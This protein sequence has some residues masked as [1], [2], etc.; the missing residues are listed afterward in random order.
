M[1]YGSADDRCQ[2]TSRT[3]EVLWRPQSRVLRR[4]LLLPP[5]LA[6]VGMVMLFP[7]RGDADNVRFMLSIYGQALLPPL[8]GWIAAGLLMGDPCRELLLAAPRPAWRALCERAALLGASA[9]AALVAL[10]AFTLLVPDGVVAPYAGQLFVGGAAVS[11]AFGGLGL[12]AGVRTRSPLAGGLIVAALWAAGLAFREQL[13]SYPLGQALHPCLLLAEP[14]SPPWL[15][16]GLA[17]GLA[18]AALAGLAL[19]ATRDEEPLLPGGTAEE[20]V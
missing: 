4:Q 5:C 13:L 6:L 9:F 19:Y 12:W 10:L 11:L 15:L 8:T 18:G 2:R 7:G 16:N 17:L 14:E 3:I 20:T 1:S